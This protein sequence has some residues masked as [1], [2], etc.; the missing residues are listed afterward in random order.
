MKAQHKSPKEADE[1]YSHVASSHA[2]AVGT[3]SMASSSQNGAPSGVSQ[4]QFS[5]QGSGA[6]SPTQPAT[7]SSAE[8]LASQRALQ[9]FNHFSAFIALAGQ[10]LECVVSQGTPL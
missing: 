9:H 7:L 3:N 4:M 1:Y 8:S 10:F 2:E 6:L 5:P